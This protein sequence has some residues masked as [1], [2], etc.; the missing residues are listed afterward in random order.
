LDQIGLWAGFILTLMVFSYILGDNLLYRLA[1]YVFVGL[2][3]GFIAVTTW[4]SVVLPWMNGTMFN[5]A[6]DLGNRILGLIPILIGL[7]LLLKTSPA[8]GR[9]G[10]LALA[11]VIGVGTAVALIG[12]VAGTLLP[13]AS[14]T[15]SMI[16]VNQINGLLLL[17]G[18]IC[19]LVY[20]QYL[21]RRLPDGQVRRRA[22]IRL[23]A[24]VGQGFVV[25]TL[26][27]LYAAAIL[28]S[29]TIFSER[30]GFMLT[31][32]MGG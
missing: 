23:L 6:A 10:H 13:L 15:S 1:V 12:A 7:L 9:F 11:F 18:V 28:T 3:A 8:L 27:A 4:E 31:Q 29:L 20:F 17:I 14:S 19:T 30:L 25:I 2:A 24:F 5:P 26:G 32:V 22:H 21:A 16:S